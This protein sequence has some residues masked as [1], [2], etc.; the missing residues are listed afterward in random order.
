MISTSTRRGDGDD[1]LS[2]IKFTMKVY[3]KGG[4]STQVYAS[5]IIELDCRETIISK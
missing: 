4:S 5:V 1:T 3:A 2:E